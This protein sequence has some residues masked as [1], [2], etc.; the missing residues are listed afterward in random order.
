MR[1][2]PENNLS[3]RVITYLLKLVGLWTSSTAIGRKILKFATIFAL[4]TNLILVYLIALDMYYGD[5]NFDDVA[6]GVLNF[7]IT[8]MSSFKIAVIIPFRE[9]FIG[10]ISHVKETFWYGTYDRDG[11]RIMNE[12]FTKCTYM[13]V[14]ISIMCFMTL[15]MFM[16]EPFIVDR[17]KGNIDRHFPVNLHF[18]FIPASTTPWYEILYII[19]FTTA[20]YCIICFL[21]FDTF[22][23]G[24]NMT[25]VGQFMILQKELRC[26]YDY[27]ESSMA[28]E[29]T[30]NL[31]FSNFVRKHQALI[32]CADNVKELYKN[33]IIGFVFFLSISI[34]MELFQIMMSTNLFIRLRAI[35]YFC[36]TT[37]ELYLF[38]LVCNSL[39]EVS[40]DISHAAYDVRWFS[41]TSDRV[42]KELM[43]GLTTV[44]M[45]SQKP[46]QMMVGNFS[47]VTLK[48]FTSICNMAFSGLTLMRT[49]LQREL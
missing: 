23:C 45:R 37:G 46:C 32:S 34:A 4:T 17:Q 24:M 3:I 8:G 2:S 10:L 36:N 41:I 39:A 9:R 25:L 12:C 44:I 48:T 43:S 5:N 33:I 38:T 28:D 13:V 35:I 21:C 7:S 49:S 6:N 40:F 16:V 47:P 42:K 19:E 29:D 30:V 14:V 1:A 31:R 20:S 22:L 26:I 18:R 27:T 15:M 11:L